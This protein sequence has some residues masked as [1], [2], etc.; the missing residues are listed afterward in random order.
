[1]T[2]IARTPQTFYHHSN[3]CPSVQ[4]LHAKLQFVVSK[5]QKIVLVKEEEWGRCL[6]SRRMHIRDTIT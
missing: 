1:M 4:N 6:F 5:K 2:R 3:S